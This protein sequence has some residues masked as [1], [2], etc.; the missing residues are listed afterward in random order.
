MDIQM[1]VMS[2]EKAAAE[3]M[4]LAKL[5]NEVPIIGITECTMAF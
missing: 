2:V 5:A 4:G 3:I 1:P